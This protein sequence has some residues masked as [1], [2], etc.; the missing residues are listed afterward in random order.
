MGWKMAREQNTETND[1]PGDGPDGGGSAWNRRAI[2][3]AL[4]G[5][6]VILTLSR[7]LAQAESAAG[8]S[9]DFEYLC[10]PPRDDLTPSQAQFCENPTP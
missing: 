2:L 4:A 1:S 9:T 10:V 3:S 5:A 6:P 7:S 8:L